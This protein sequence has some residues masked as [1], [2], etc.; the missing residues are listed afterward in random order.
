MDEVRDS[1]SF[2]AVFDCARSSNGLARLWCRETDNYAA[3]ESNFKNVFWQHSANL[4]YSEYAPNM[5]LE[6]TEYNRVTKKYDTM[7]EKNQNSRLQNEKPKFYTLICA[8]KRI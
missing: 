3:R 5:L 2:S 4:Y 6:E 1:V 8:K 7:Q